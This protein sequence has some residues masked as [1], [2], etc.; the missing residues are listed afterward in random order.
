MDVCLYGLKNIVKHMWR[1]V[2]VVSVTLILAKLSFV[3]SIMHLEG[4]FAYCTVF[5]VLELKELGTAEL[6][7]KLKQDVWSM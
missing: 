4:S 7:E 5:S 2:T 3:D 6:E 1:L